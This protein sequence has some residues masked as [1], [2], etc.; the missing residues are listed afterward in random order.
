M[1]RLFI[2]SDIGDYSK[3]LKRIITKI[4]DE[5]N[6]D[7]ILI[8]LG[9]NFYP[10]GIKDINDEQINKFVKMFS[11]LDNKKYMILG[12]HD[13]ILSP[14]SQINNPNWNM[15]NWFYHIDYYECSLYFLDTIQ[16]YPSECV[17]G[18][19]IKEQHNEILKN[20]YEKQLNWLEENL[21]LSN[22][23]HKFVF[24]H[25]PLVSNG[26]YY[27]SFVK[28]YKKLMPLFEKYKV[29]A[30]FSGH[31]HSFQYIKREINNY[32]FNQFICGNTGNIRKEEEK[33]KK[34]DN[35]E[36]IFYNKSYCYMVVTINDMY[37]NIS[38]K[39]KDNELYNINC[40]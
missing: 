1:C 23:K 15:P 9:D 22:K 29:K 28:L 10:I 40:E 34:E 24:G 7:D 21:K 18:M 20:L 11:G 8:I 33:Y 16:L 26:A 30:Y 19:R 17:D 37:I 2:I 13:Y 4:K 3:H 14:Q 5:I 6:K 39:D 38:I 12:N 25:Y 36:D 35:N 27:Y 31:E 32:T